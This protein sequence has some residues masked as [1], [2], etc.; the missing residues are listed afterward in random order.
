MPDYTTLMPGGMIQH[1]LPLAPKPQYLLCMKPLTAS[2]YRT[3]LLS[4]IRVVG[5]LVQW[6]L[7][8]M[9]GV[10]RHLVI[11]RAPAL[12]KHA[13]RQVGVQSQSRLHLPGEQADRGVCPVLAVTVQI[14][15]EP[16]EMR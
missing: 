7:M 8:E 3:R 2:S 9:S 5:G 15:A 16:L 4:S 13:R 12:A 6:M 14:F 1:Q 11:A 10:A